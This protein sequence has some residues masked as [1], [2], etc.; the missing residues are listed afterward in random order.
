M[1]PELASRLKELDERPDPDGR[2]RISELFCAGEVWRN[3]VRRLIADTDLVV[4]DLRSFSKT[5]EG[6]AFELQTLLDAAPL[7]RLVLLIDRDT[8][9]DLLKSLL[10]ARWRDLSAAS[11]NVSAANP[12]VP[13]L[14]V[15]RA[16][17]AIV[18]CLMQRAARFRQEGACALFRGRR[19]RHAMRETVARPCEQSHG[20]RQLS[21]Y[22]MKSRN[23]VSDVLSRDVLNHDFD[24]RESRLAIPLRE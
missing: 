8:D 14:K 4:M 6:C 13:L 11:I 3:A 1:R 20:G 2:F 18:R 19:P 10:E 21:S 23:A 17:S 7:N 15:D 22:N 16:E 5:N 12:S 24:Y 9:V